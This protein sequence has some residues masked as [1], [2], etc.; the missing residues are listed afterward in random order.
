M[1]RGAIGRSQRRR[2]S[3][4]LAQFRA[5]VVDR[6]SRNGPASVP[7]CPCSDVPQARGRRRRRGVL[8][9]AHRRRTSGQPPLSRR[10]APTCR[11]CRTPTASSCRSGSAD[12]VDHGRRPDGGSPR[13]VRVG[14]RGRTHRRPPS[15]HRSSRRCRR[16]H[17]RRADRAVRPWTANPTPSGIRLL[18]SALVTSVRWASAMARRRIGGIPRGGIGVAHQRHH[19]VEQLVCHVTL[20][21]VPPIVTAKVQL[22]PKCYPAGAAVIGVEPTPLRNALGDVPVRGF[23]RVRGNA[24]RLPGSRVGSRYGEERPACRRDD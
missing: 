12:S 7:W 15:P 17:R 4:V 3:C 9:P 11:I 8:R 14:V 16:R 23:G 19:E 18:T 6:R 13:R 21:P 2:T 20:L 5:L 24:R 22:V 1:T 10:T